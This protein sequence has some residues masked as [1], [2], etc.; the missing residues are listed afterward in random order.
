[1]RRESS[2]RYVEGAEPGYARAVCMKTERITHSTRGVSNKHK[3]VRRIVLTNV[4][5]STYIRISGFSFAFSLVTRVTR[6]AERVGRG[7][8]AMGMAWASR[9]PPR[10]NRNS[11]ESVGRNNVTQAPNA[12]PAL[13][14]LHTRELCYCSHTER[15]DDGH[16]HRSDAPHTPELAMSSSFLIAASQ[17]ESD[18]AAITSL[19]A[20]FE[21]NS[22]ALHNQRL[23]TWL[24]A[25]SIGTECHYAGLPKCQRPCG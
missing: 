5:T 23:Y 20:A 14:G 24:N 17:R 11:S 13:P 8:W 19:V 25:S 15:G 10:D 2:T 7:A 18:C 12:G 1:M 4:C 9:D 22:R 3:P 6:T 16:H 21:S